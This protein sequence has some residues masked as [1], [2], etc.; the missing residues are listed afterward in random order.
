M[1]TEY[2]IIFMVNI[3]QISSQVMSQTHQMATKVT[4]AQK[5]QVQGSALP[6]ITVVLQ[7]LTSQDLSD[8]SL[9]LA[10]SQAGDGGSQRLITILPILSSKDGLF[11]AIESTPLSFYSK[12][13]LVPG[14][15]LVAIGQE[16]ALGLK[17]QASSLTLLDQDLQLK[18]QQLQQQ[19]LPSSSGATHTLTKDAQHF[20]PLMLAIQALAPQNS[21]PE[22]PLHRVLST[23]TPSQLSSPPLEWLSKHDYTAP[24][25]PPKPSWIQQIPG[26]AQKVL[27]QQGLLLLDSALTQITQ[28]YNQ[29]S[30]KQVSQSIL[31]N[32][33]EAQT[34]QNR[35]PMTNTLQQTYSIQTSAL[36]SQST[37]IDKPNTSGI[38]GITI[39]ESWV[40]LQKRWLEMPHSFLT[41][42][43]SHLSALQLYQGSGLR[44]VI[45]Q[46]QHLWPEF[47]NAGHIIRQF[48][49][50]TLNQTS[51]L[52]AL[53]KHLSTSGGLFEH[54]FDGLHNQKLTE[55]HTSLLKAL[56]LRTTL[57]ELHQ[58]MTNSSD[59]AQ[60]TDAKEIQ[61]SLPYLTDKQH[62]SWFKTSIHAPA[63]QNSK[64]N[65]ALGQWLMLDFESTAL[66]PIRFKLTFHQGFQHPICQS[67]VWIENP[68]MIQA[69]QQYQ[70]QLESHL[71]KSGLIVEQFNWH[72]ATPPKDS[73]I[74]SSNPKFQ[75]D[76]YV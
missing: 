10:Q 25:A 45:H 43:K 67:S 28:D 36:V 56:L 29:D 32:N 7:V 53:N 1:Q 47:E 61:F 12:I 26:M 19:Q 27:L 68:E 74:Y 16:S 14:E 63:D 44:G 62:T 52:L 49:T 31:M 71:A 65:T 37:P 41:D 72:Q 13:N 11:S 40:Q 34:N 17:L 70:P 48:Q 22:S 8:S 39:I 73:N 4:D 9:P 33:K 2:E 69:F 15:L 20:K 64:S 3:E 59:N 21:Q 54:V 30:A 50:Q 57:A 66:G 35:A 18:L 51:L 38:D 6:P 58:N 23:L 76:D 46:L 24:N 5:T 75:I 55:H 42:P 60:Q